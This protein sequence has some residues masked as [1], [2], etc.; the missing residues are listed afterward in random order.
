MHKTRILLG[1]LWVFTAVNVAFVVTA[2]T[3]YG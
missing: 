1:A 3:V 2:L